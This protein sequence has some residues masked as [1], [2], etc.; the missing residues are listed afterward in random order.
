MSRREKALA[1]AEKIRESQKSAARD[2]SENKENLDNFLVLPDHVGEDHKFVRLIS[3]HHRQIILALTVTAVVLI[4]W[5]LFLT[6]AHNES[7]FKRA[8]SKKA[9]APSVLGQLSLREDTNLWK[10]C[11]NIYGSVDQNLFRTFIR[12]NSEYGIWELVEKQVR[13]NHGIENVQIMEHNKNII[14]PAITASG[15]NMINAIWVEIARAKTLQ[16]GYDLLG[17]YAGN[18]PRV[19]LFPFWNPREQM[20]Y[21]LLLKDRFS[22]RN[23][24]QKAIEKLPSPMIRGA[25]I[26]DRWDDDT[27]FYHRV[28]R[29]K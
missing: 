13:K 28:S 22:D 7:S 4:G 6:L 12:A 3:R 16:E 8:A 21:A 20:V 14:I 1:L 27:I 26:I 19:M 10:L 25:R 17:T 9:A 29:L 15:N 23:I 2:V 18:M 11:R 24:A 5:L